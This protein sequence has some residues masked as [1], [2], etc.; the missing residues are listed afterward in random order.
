VSEAITCQSDSGSLHNGVMGLLLPRLMQPEPLG[1][2]QLRAHTNFHVLPAPFDPLGGGPLR[3]GAFFGGAGSMICAL[4]TRLSVTSPGH[5]LGLGKVGVARPAVHNHRAR[6][7]TR[8][9]AASTIDAMLDP[10]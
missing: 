6:L 4:R 9:K 2:I 3:R 8:R 5:L 1:L 10:Q 7:T